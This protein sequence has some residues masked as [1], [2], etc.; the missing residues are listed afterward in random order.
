MKSSI[1]ESRLAFAV[2]LLAALAADG[3]DEQDLS[4]QLANPLADLISVPVQMNY[5][6]NLG[7]DNDGSAFS[8][9]VQPVL[10][11]Q[12]NEDWLV[13]SR[14]IIPF[15]HLE[16]VTVFDRDQTGLGDV[17]QS[18]FFS[19]SK[20]TE[21]GWIW[22]GGPALLLPTATDDIL[23]SDQWA[24]GPTAVALKQSGPWTY[25]VLANHL[26]SLSGGNQITGFGGA[27]N[28]EQE[29]NASYIEP[30]VSFAAD[31]GTTYSLSAEMS[32]NWDANDWAVPIVL[33]ADHLFMNTPTPIS[34]GVA[35]R[36]W[37]D[38][39]SGYPGGWSARLQVTFLFPK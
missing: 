35:A 28:L 31:H 5:D 2:L 18:V 1:K 10:P 25:G 21:S 16:D 9:N 17:L 13:I 39:P 27:V 37:M 19:P 32:Y 8:I 15:I 36:Y 33:T 23:G 22:G 29:V 14:T 20:A 7:I 3:Q 6:N 30:W 24:L 4:K 34:V 26:W 12:L 38:S 11:F